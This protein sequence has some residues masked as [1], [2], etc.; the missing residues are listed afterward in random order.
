MKTLGADF[1]LNLDGA[2]S[3]ALWYDGAYKVG[4]GRLLPNAILFRKK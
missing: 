3:A 1:A 2:G 4:P